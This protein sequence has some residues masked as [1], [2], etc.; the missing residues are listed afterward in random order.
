MFHNFSFPSTALFIFLIIF[1]RWR[2]HASF[3]PSLFPFL[4]SPSL[5]SFPPF[6]QQILTSVSLTSL[7]HPR[8]DK[9]WPITLFLFF[10]IVLKYLMFL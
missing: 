6:V 4:F 1:L 3:L 5:S 10:L 2:Y 9:L 8:L 7:I